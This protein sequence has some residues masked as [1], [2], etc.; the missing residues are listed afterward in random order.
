MMMV[1]RDIEKVR[2]DLLEMVA[3]TSSP[4]PDISPLQTSEIWRKR[5][6]HDEGMLRTDL[7][8][9]LMDEGYITPIE[10]DEHSNA[11]G[12]GGWS[13]ITWKGMR[14]LD[15]LKHP[16][17]YWLRRNWFAATVAAVTTVV[18]VG[19]LVLDAVIN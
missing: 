2:I 18:S 4:D 19:S 6:P 13:S 5:F 7:M 1:Q 17:Y 10:R 12:G 11:K 8:A 14:H 9:E 15:E 3:S 16:T